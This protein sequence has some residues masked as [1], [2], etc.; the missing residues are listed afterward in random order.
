[1]FPGNIH[2][3]FFRIFPRALWVTVWAVSNA[4]IF[5]QIMEP[6]SIVLKRY[7]LNGSWKVL[8]AKEIVQFAS[9]FKVY[10]F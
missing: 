8:K 1:M 4:L 6:S 5:L 10:P 9:D 7:Q 3:N 2:E